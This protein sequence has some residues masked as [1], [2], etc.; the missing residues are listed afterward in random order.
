MDENIFMD[1]L[2]AIR[3]GAVGSVQRLLMADPTLE[4]KAERH[5]ILFLALA[6]KCGQLGVVQAL[7]QHMKGRGLDA[8][9]M[10]GGTALHYAAKKGYEGVV[11]LLL[12][13]G[14]QAN[15][16]D[17]YNYTPL[18]CASARG[19][20]VVVK[21]LAHH[22]G[23]QG[24]DETDDDEDDEVV[25]EDQEGNTALHCA[26]FWGHDQVVR[27]LLLAGADPTIMDNAGKTPR[28]SVEE[29]MRGALV[30]DESH[31]KCVALFEVSKTRTTV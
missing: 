29:Q 25:Y 7:L 27:F 9:D 6:A 31:A 19:H 28:T 14:A 21:I 23:G 22:L 15:S 16:R 13:H 4:E 18:I 30:L 3:E 1:L 5:G 12:K 8:R 26:A 17:D 2:R 10:D 24:L 20:L 11:A